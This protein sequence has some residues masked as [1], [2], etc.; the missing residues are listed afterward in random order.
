MH[1]TTVLCGLVAFS[2]SLT[3]ADPASLVKNQPPGVQYVATLP[4]TSAV[5]G[6]VM[7]GTGNSG[8]GVQVQVSFANLPT[9]GGPY[10]E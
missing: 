4:E 1:L 10:R 3:V 9:S 5:S 2:V 8:D 6:S 7:I